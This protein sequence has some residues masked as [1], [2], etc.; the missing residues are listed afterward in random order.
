MNVL[1]VSRRSI[2]RC[3][4]RVSWAMAR[5]AG[6]S[7]T[8]PLAGERLAH[9]VGCSGGGDTVAA[10]AHGLRG[11]IA[12]VHAFRAILARSASVFVDT[13]G[14]ALATAHTGTTGSE[15]R[16]ADSRHV[17]YFRI[18]CDDTMRNNVMRCDRRRRQLL[19]D[20][21]CDWLWYGDDCRGLK[22]LG[23]GD[24]ETNA[25]ESGGWVRYNEGMCQGTADVKKAQQNRQGKDTGKM[26]EE[27]GKAPKM[28]TDVILFFRSERRRRLPVGEGGGKGKKGNE[29]FRGR[30]RSCQ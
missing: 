8:R 16:R 30:P 27:M 18:R 6:T 28:T 14:L 13:L 20:N 5:V 21:V 10:M 7:T 12:F 1:L 11:Q 15:G 3:D 29:S 4:S 19:F 2:A 9:T 26:K 24:P 17:E 25:K 23:F 22:S